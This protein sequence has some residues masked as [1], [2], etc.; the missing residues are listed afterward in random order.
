M[1]PKEVS[2]DKGK[3]EREEPQSR[4]KRR[5][6]PKQLEDKA[7][8]L[9]P[10]PPSLI[11]QITKELA[12]SWEQKN[13]KPL[14]NG[15]KASLSNKVTTQSTSETA[16][17]LINTGKACTVGTLKIKLPVPPLDHS[18]RKRT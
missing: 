17:E 11:P 9:E 5:L 18:L 6:A 8:E 2:N 13:A 15:P 10:L 7:E 1:E 4:K 14:A 16:Q 12:E 3:G